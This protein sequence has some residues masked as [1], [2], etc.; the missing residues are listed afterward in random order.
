MT[1]NNNILI[2]IAIPFYNAEKYLSSAVKSVLK[3]TYED[4]CMILVD[5]GS[6]DS[7]L[8]IAKKFEESDPRIKVFSDGENRNLGFRLNQI[9]V[10]TTTKYLGRMDAD[11]IMHPEKIEKQMTILLQNQEI[12]VI[13]TNAYSINEE[14]KVV[15]IRYKDIDKGVLLNVDSFI[16][17]TIIAK[18]EWFRKNRYDDNALRIEDK[19]LWYRTSDQSNFKMIAEPLF[20]YR[21]VGQNYYQKY[22]KANEAKKYILKKY[23]N[24]RFWKNFFLQ[25]IVKGIVY[26]FFRL[27]DREDILVLKRNQ[28]IFEKKLDLDEYISQK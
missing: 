6:T 18:T 10:L 13:G 20:F 17:P 25:N 11:D 2:T 28:I 23:D 7:S 4:W 27:L 14:N 9:S 21:E 16:H 5:D 8:E 15:G 24:S 3:Q 12:D 22:F 1:K 19:E 26:R